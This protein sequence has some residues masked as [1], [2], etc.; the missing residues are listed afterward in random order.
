[1]LSKIGARI[2]IPSR[3]ANLTAGQEKDRCRLTWQSFDEKCYMVSFGD[4]GDLKDYVGDVKSFTQNKKD[5]WLCFSDEIP[6]WIKIG[7]LKTIFANWELGTCRPTKAARLERNEKRAQASQT[8][9]KD[10]AQEGELPQGEKMADNEGCTQRRGAERVGEKCRI[11]FEA[12]QA[13]SGYFGGDPSKIQGH[14]LL[15]AIILKSSGWANL[16]EH[17]R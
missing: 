9:D 13:I 8:I 7:L 1:M 14:I 15:S 2:G 12:R 5:T 16:P 4:A 3:A 17:H 11:T 6:L 10:E